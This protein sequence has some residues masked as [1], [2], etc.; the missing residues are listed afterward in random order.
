MGWPSNGVNDHWMYTTEQQAL[1]AVLM[2]VG[3]W[4]PG[5]AKRLAMDC[6][7]RE[8]EDARASLRSLLKAVGPGQAKY[9]GEPKRRAEYAVA[10]AQEI[11]GFELGDA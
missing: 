6:V 8:P 5:T 9:A 11:Y 1:W 3:M 4:G 2:V 7:Q 10:R